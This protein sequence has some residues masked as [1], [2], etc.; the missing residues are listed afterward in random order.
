M[1]H[2]TFVCM[3]KVRHKKVMHLNI[4]KSLPVNEPES[5]KD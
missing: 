4:E 3:L 2:V 5:Y 1:L